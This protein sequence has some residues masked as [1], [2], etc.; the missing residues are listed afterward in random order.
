MLLGLVLLTG[1]IDKKESLASYC[2]ADELIATLFFNKC[3]SRNQF[4]LLTTFLHFNNNDHT[5]VN[6]DDKLNKIRTVYSIVVSRWHELY[7][8][9]EHISIDEGMLKWRGRLSFRVYMKNKS[10][11]YG[12]KSNILANLKT[13][14]CW[15]LDI[16]HRLKKTLKETVQGMLT[17]KCLH[18]WHSL[19]MDNFYNSVDLS[20]ALLDQKVHTVGTLRK[21]RGKP[22]AIKNTQRMQHHD[23]RAVDNGKVMVLAWKDKQIIKAISIIH[24]DLVCSLTRQKKEE[25]GDATK[26]GIDCLL[27][28]AHVW[29]RSFGSN[30]RILSLHQKD[31]EVDQE[32]FLLSDG[33][34]CPQLLYFI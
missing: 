23:I 7:S 32:G 33:N 6:C 2:S 18:L 1:L 27:Q 21:H 17:E 28:P 9:G 12:I 3:I 31:T 4:Q 13:H 29:S 30:D 22:S 15:N 16:F 11:K 26:A 25:H 19:Y 24:D 5:P 34:Q 10:V 20:L 8:M 14:Y